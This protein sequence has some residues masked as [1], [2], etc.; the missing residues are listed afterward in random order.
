MINKK[1]LWFALQWGSSMDYKSLEMLKVLYLEK[2]VTKA[3]EKLYISQPALTYKIK[4]MENELGV[5]ILHRTKQG[6][7]FTPEG[8]H[9]VTYAEKMLHDYQHLKDHLKNMNEY[10]GGIIRMGVSRNFARYM[11]PSILQNFL[12]DHHKVQFNIVTSWSQSLVKMIKNDEINIAIV[13]G[14]FSWNFERILLEEEPICVVH[15]NKID[16]RDLPDLPRI[17]FKT[18][19]GLRRIIDHWW[20]D[21][22]SKPPL[23]T[24]ELDN[25]ETCIELVNTGL[26]YA[27]IPAIG[28]KKRRNIESIALKDKNDDPLFRKTWLL[29][30]KI[31]LEYPVMHKFITFLKEEYPE[32]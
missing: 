1:N 28:L 5:K 18:D 11:L 25:I 27:I 32:L 14:D 26:G 19:P 20:N 9:L 24:M 2:N 12:E 23:I 15:K 16:I 7:K 29:F 31:D 4:S 21:N 30:R 8:E 3:A 22:F 13:R 6:I 17:D 10:D